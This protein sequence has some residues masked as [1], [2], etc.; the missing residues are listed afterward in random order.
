MLCASPS[1]QLSVPARTPSP[2]TALQTEGEPT[3]VKPVSVVHCAE[4][5]SPPCASLS[6]HVSV[7][8]MTPSP[9][10]VVQTDGSAV[11]QE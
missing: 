3:H 8:T 6:S 11:V 7:P 4:Q 9:Q 1:S 2:Q 10:T 5:P